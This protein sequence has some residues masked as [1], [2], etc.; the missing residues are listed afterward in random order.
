[1]AAS[2]NCNGERTT[3]HAVL[4][5]SPKAVVI[6]MVG[7]LW[8]VPIMQRTHTRGIAIGWER[9][10]RR[11]SRSL[12]SFAYGARSSSRP[13]ARPQAARAPRDRRGCV[14]VLPLVLQVH[15]SQATVI[16]NGGS[17]RGEG[18]AAGHPPR[19]HPLFRLF[20][21]SEGSGWL[22]GAATRN[23]A[24]G[25]TPLLRLPPCRAS[26]CRARAPRSTRVTTT[27]VASG[28]VDVNRRRRCG[29][30]RGAVAAH[31]ARRP[32]GRC[33]RGAAPR[34]AALVHRL[35]RTPYALP[36]LAR[37]HASTHACWVRRG[38]QRWW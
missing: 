19:S 35:V 20:L 32:R 3:H 36:R 6:S 27:P 29:E 14:L 15:A 28:R 18:G 1:M 31:P 17:W 30:G 24:V 8:V 23:A 11:L 38:R 22:P 34:G 7:G 12:F 5:K 9:A 16:Q 21:P 25:H 2:L 26:G 37:G 4:R 33:G 13:P 10:S